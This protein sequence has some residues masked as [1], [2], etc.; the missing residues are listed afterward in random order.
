MPFQ[1]GGNFTPFTNAL[2]WQDGHDVWPDL[3]DEALVENG[4]L[5]LHPDPANRDTHMPGP[6]VDGDDSPWIMGRVM[7]GFDIGITDNFEVDLLQVA[8]PSTLELLIQVSP[9]IY[10]TLDP[11]SD[12][13]QMGVCPV[14]DV[15][16]NPNYTYLQNCFRSP[17]PDAFDPVAYY[18]HVPGTL[19]QHTISG[20]AHRWWKVRVQNGLVTTWLDTVRVHPP[21]DVEAL[22]PWV[23]GRTMIGVHIIHFHVEPGRVWPGSPFVIDTEAR[24]RV[25]VFRWRELGGS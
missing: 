19:R 24:S 14:I 21:L 4:Q 9:F 5:T 10:G 11:E 7:A 1:V 17:I 18:E 3:F 8:T 12:P 25:G 13:V 22:W 23:A 2:D 20:R 15:A 16:L 6:W